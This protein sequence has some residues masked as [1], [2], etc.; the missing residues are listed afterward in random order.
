MQSRAL[1]PGVV[2]IFITVAYFG[3]AWSGIAL[4]IGLA[5]KSNETATAGGSISSITVF[6]LLF[7][8]T[9]DSFRAQSDQLCN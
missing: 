4:T 2:L 5:T 6:P 8:S 7:T 9:A 3:I 1:V